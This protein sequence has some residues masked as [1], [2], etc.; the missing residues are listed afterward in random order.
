MWQN[1]GTADPFLLH[2]CTTAA[3]SPSRPPR[4]KSRNLVGDR[5]PIGIRHCSGVIGRVSV[6]EG[7]VMKRRQSHLDEEEEEDDERPSIATV[8]APK[9]RFIFAATDEGGSARVNTVLRSEQRSR[10][11]AA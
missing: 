7:G 3:G 1:D 9:R 8:N 5:K 6:G 11:L 10:A 2:H 4:R